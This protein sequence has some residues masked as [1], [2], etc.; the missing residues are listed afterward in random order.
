MTRRFESP[1][2][3]NSRSSPSVVIIGGGLAGIAAAV[4]LT[5]GGV[6]VGL[7]ET[8]KRL[9][10]RA[11]SFVDPTTGHTLDNCQHVLMG[12]CTNLLDLYRRLGVTDLICWHR[13][14]Y[15]ADTQGVIDCLEADDLPAPMHMIRSLM[16][17]RSLTWTEK[18]AIARA[19]VAMIRLGPTDRQRLHR[20]TFAH[21]LAGYRQPPSAIRKFWSVIVTSALNE[22]LDRVDAAYAV[23]VFQDGFLAHEGAYVMGLPTVPLVKLYETAPRIIT[24]GGGSVL[25]SAGAH[26]FDFDGR[27]VTALRLVDGRRLTADAFIAAIPP[28]RLKKL[29]PDS[30]CQ[31]DPRLQTLGDIQTSP[32]IGVHLWF[33][34]PADHPLMAW[35]HLIFTDGPLQWIFNKGRDDRLA[36][37]HL[38]GV[39]S[40]AY[41]LVDVSAQEIIALATAQLEKTLAHA[42]PGAGARLIHGRVVKEKRATFSV[43]PGIDRLRS[44]TRGQID[45]LYLAGDW[46]HTH[47]P[48][49]MEGATRSGYLAAAALAEDLETHGLQAANGGALVADLPAHALYRFCCRGV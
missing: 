28:D 43:I 37:Q 47:W 13:R 26:G 49:T 32:I 2:G 46:C 19:M 15:F 16:A 18:I 8:R 21:W 40:A 11:T 25:F 39:I 45:N 30:M 7:V 42:W 10:G 1:G 22:Q 23:Q 27:R 31:A 14:L 17:F 34:T 44:A 9:G 24:E 33:A 4:K 35:P 38:H 41:D 12:C 5:A 36:G 20:V 6:A 29:I 3:S 48:A